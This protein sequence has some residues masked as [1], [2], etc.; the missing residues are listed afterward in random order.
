MVLFKANEALPRI[1]MF[2]SLE[3]LGG[4]FTAALMMYGADLRKVVDV[5]LN[6]AGRCWEAL[7][8]ST[9]CCQ[10]AGAPPQLR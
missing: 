1:P 8:R 5:L 2:V 7:A 3:P 9:Q 6:S 10:C 4:A